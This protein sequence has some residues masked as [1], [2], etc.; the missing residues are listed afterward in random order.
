MNSFK[1]S[2]LK[3]IVCICV[4]Y[5]IC[6]L[7]IY[8]ICTLWTPLQ[9]ERDWKIHTEGLSKFHSNIY[10]ILFVLNIKT[11][12][13]SFE[14]WIRTDC[15]LLIFFLLKTRLYTAINILFKLILL[16][17]SIK[18]NDVGEFGMHNN[19]IYKI[20]PFVKKFLD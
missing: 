4:L 2:K 8:M 20:S 1:N 10:S 16:F 17:W 15:E 11:W 12:K 7:N 6:F 5:C 9:A 3:W 18:Q 14:N 19:V 13:S